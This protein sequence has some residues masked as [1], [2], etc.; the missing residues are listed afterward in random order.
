MRKPNL[1][2]VGHPRCGTTALY[3]YLKGHPDVFMSTIKEPNFF[4]KDFHEESDRYHRKRI[5][6]PFRKET[7]YLKLYRKVRGESILGEASA[8]NLYSKVAAQKIHEFNP[9]ARIII[10]L[11]EPVS[12]VYSYHAQSTFSN[13]EHVYDFK[14]ALSVENKRKQWKCLSKRVLVPSWLFYSELVRYSDQVY[15]FLDVFDEPQVRIII[16]DDFRKNTPKIFQQILDFLSVDPDYRHDFKV[17]NP[18][19]QVRFPV[20]KYILETPALYRIPRKILSH[21]AY[22]RLVQYYKTFIVTYQPRVPLDDDFRRELMRKFKPEVEKISDVIQRD[23]VSL[24]GYS[25]I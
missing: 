24:W 5:F 16:F 18:N 17:M 9:D 15:R 3:S 22:S 2:I 25:Q 19:K 6:F 23:L 8:L 13:G 14:D 12:F 20:L 1:F 7:D 21:D 11:R 4:Q 10:M